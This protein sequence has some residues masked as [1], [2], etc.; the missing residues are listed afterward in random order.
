[1]LCYN[2][3]Y[4]VYEKQTF[5]YDG[6]RVIQEHKKTAYGTGINRGTPYQS[7]DTILIS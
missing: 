6:W 4:P 2:P 1:V 7:G 3:Q 5:A